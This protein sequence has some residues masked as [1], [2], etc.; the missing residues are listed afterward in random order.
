MHAFASVAYLFFS[1]TNLLDGFQEN[2][3]SL[4][5][6]NTKLEEEIS[7]IF[8]CLQGLKVHLHVVYCFDFIQHFSR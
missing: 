7:V 3:R 2:C 6:R 4:M 8:I 1:F 5:E